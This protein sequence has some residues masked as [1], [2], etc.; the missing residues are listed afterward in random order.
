MALRVTLHVTL[1]DFDRA[2]VWVP[3]SVVHDDSEVQGEGDEGL[4][5]VADWY[6]RKTLNEDDDAF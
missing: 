1:H 5:I 2:N 6:A 4:L 3:K